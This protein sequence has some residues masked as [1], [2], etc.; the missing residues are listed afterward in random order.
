[1]VTH[2][3]GLETVD[4]AQAGVPATDALAK[5]GKQEVVPL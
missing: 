4:V 1:L 3:A 5:E 2:H